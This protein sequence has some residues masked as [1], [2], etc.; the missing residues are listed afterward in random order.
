MIMANNKVKELSDKELDNLSIKEMK[1]ILRQAIE[2]REENEGKPFDRAVLSNATYILYNIAGRKFLYDLFPEL[3]A[4]I[5]SW[6]SYLIQGAVISLC[7]WLKFPETKNEFKNKIHEIFA[8]NQSIKIKL[9]FLLSWNYETESKFSI[10]EV[11][12]VSNLAIES[13]GSREV[14]IRRM[15]KKM[16][17]NLLES[18]I[19]TI[20]NKLQNK[21][22]EWIYL[23]DF[24]ASDADEILFKEE[25]LTTTGNFTKPKKFQD[26]EIVNIINPSKEN[27]KFKYFIGTVTG[28]SKDIHGNWFH[29]V[30]FSQELDDGCLCEDHELESMGKFAKWEDFYG[31]TTEIIKVIVTPDGKGKLKEEQ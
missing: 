24:L 16:L 18:P 26:M 27:K 31:E 1:A 15:G 10:Y 19:A 6:D 21:K 2:L 17:K 12:K 28:Y 7:W 8:N 25:D 13:V 30:R 4:L 22:G 9:N 20:T 14:E 23:L 5:S 29:R 11:V 3:F